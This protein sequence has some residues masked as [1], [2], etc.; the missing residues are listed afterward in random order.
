MTAQEIINKYIAFFEKRG[1]K[2]IPSASLIPENDPTALFTSAGMHPLVPYLLGQPHPSGKR[3][4]SV[5]KCLRTDDIDEVGDNIHHTFFEMLGNW[6]FG[7]YFK[8]EAIQ[9]SYEFLTS[10][11]WLNIPKNKLAISVF[12]G[13]NDAPFDQESYEIWLS[14]GVPKER[15]AKLPKKNNWWG[16]AG[17]TG[18]CGPDTEMFY[19][20]GKETAPVDFDPQNT[21]WVE[22]WNDVFM[23][24]NKT[25]DGKFELLKQKN[26]DTGMG[27]ERALAV[28]NGFD[29]NYKTGLF[30][31]LIQNIEESTGLKYGE[32]SDNEYIEEGEQCWVDT[33]KKM[34]II[35]DHIRAATFL[36]ADGV[37]PSNKLQGYV[38]RKLLR[39]AA[40]KAFSIN[41]DFD[42]KNFKSLAQITINIYKSYFA[43]INQEE[44]LT[45]I[46]L[47]I[48][49]FRATLERGLQRLDK[50][51]K[52]NENLGL[53]VFN[54]FQSYG[55]PPELSIELLRDR[56]IKFSKSDMKQFEDAKKSHIELSRTASAGMFKG[57]LQ[58]HS[59]VTTR[60]HTAT[61]LLHAALRQ[62]LG[63]H[64]KQAGSNITTERMRFDFSH[65]TKL[66]DE[67]LKKVENLVNEKVKENL[68]VTH[69]EMSKEAAL[70]S[71]ALGF[72]VEKYG[73]MVTVYSIGNFSREICGGPHVAF[74]SEL[75]SFKIIKQENIGK[76]NR[77]IYAKVES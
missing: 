44:I 58:D 43:K 70:E 1:H 42:V 47:E 15:I 59:E 71:G 53:T 65:P 64:V 67:E 40:S 6:S 28:L 49:K 35:A 30:W 69:E 46:S 75:K 11:E 37:I 57:G 38:L 31:P 61:H 60:Y 8:K 74:T 62:I 26:V 68:P 14:L 29:D 24:Y 73:D 50:A 72:F 17:Q 41:K 36:L 7:D 18:P 10:N 3:L 34:R 4:A 51:I 13:D 63:P 45:E 25:S 22:I 77:R 54:L 16:P 76:G 21:N 39:R 66:T 56:K 20:S 2:I 32:K 19:W 27:M 55:Y 52:D 33:R 48:R 12:A 9:W 23:E 5:Q